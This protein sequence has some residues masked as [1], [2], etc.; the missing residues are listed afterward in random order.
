MPNP[1]RDREIFEMLRSGAAADEVQNRLAQLTAEDRQAVLCTACFLVDEIKEE[2]PDRA[3]EILDFIA[4]KC[5]M[6]CSANPRR[7]VLLSPPSE[8]TKSRTSPL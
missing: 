8:L 7:C 1:L 4:S 2:Y 3:G 6:R 5:A